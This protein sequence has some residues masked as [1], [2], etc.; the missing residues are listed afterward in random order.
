MGTHFAMEAVRKIHYGKIHEVLDMSHI[1]PEELKQKKKQVPEEGYFADGEEP[2]QNYNEVT[3]EDA[4]TREGV[5]RRESMSAAEKTFC[6]K[7]ANVVQC[8][9]H[10]NKQCI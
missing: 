9:V 6:V 8:P 10:T 5:L 3:E 7:A 2:S 4:T 1:S